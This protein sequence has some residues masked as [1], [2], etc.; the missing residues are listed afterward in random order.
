MS[1][2][3][4]VQCLNSSNEEP[5]IWFLFCSRTHIQ[6]AG[7]WSGPCSLNELKS[8]IH[9]VPEMMLWHPFC[10]LDI[11]SILKCRKSCHESGHMVITPSV[12]IKFPLWSK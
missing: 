7:V 5:T 11:Y 2:R 9:G 12:N 6:L 3:T 1:K 4:S 8:E 10:P